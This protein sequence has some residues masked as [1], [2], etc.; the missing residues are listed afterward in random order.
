MKNHNHIQT[1]VQS[2]RGKEWLIYNIYINKYTQ[3]DN[4]T[5]SPELQIKK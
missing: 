3:E 5:S 2:N 1:A 4:D